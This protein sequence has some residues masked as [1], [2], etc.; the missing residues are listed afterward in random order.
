MENEHHKEIEESIPMCVF[1]PHTPSTILGR[2]CCPFLNTSYS[3]GASSSD[4]VR[5]QTQEFLE[6][7][8]GTQPRGGTP[9]LQPQACGLFRLCTSARGASRWPRV[10][11]CDLRLSKSHFSLLAPKP[12]C[13][14]F[15][16][17]LWTCSKGCPTLLFLWGP[18]CVWL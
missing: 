1:L 7:A 13:I 9:R 11:H 5:S 17:W 10:Q 12:S 14:S 4:S 8:T 15:L 6:T 16:C 2:V 18:A 3:R